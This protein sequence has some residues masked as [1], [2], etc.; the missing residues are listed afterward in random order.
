[1]EAFVL[2]T[3]GTN[4]QF[5]FQTQLVLRRDLSNGEGLNPEAQPLRVTSPP[6]ASSP[7]PLTLLSRAAECSPTSAAPE[8]LCVCVCVRELMCCNSV[9]SPLQQERVSVLG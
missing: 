6:R 3:R 4:P 5:N 9:S 1:M 8:D 2:L 7:A